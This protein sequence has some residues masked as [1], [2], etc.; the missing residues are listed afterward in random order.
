M[1]V[2]TIV[3]S[4]IFACGA[5]VRMPMP[6]RTA[7]PSLEDGI[8]A[9]RSILELK[10]LAKEDKFLKLL[11]QLQTKS[12]GVD[13]DSGRPYSPSPRLLAN[14]CRCSQLALGNQPKYCHFRCIP[15]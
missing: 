8:E 12:A 15:N 5:A 7:A 3:C 6:P 10:H 4:W 11:A 1:K 14:A 2:S 13:E 9:I